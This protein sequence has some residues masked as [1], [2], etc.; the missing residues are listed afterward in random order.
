MI[1]SGWLARLATYGGLAMLR[2]PQ[3]RHARL[4]LFAALL[5]T[6]ALACPAAPAVGASTFALDRGDDPDPPAQACTTTANDCSLRGALLAANA[7]PG[8][9]T[10]SL[11]AG[12]YTLSIKGTDNAAHTGDLD[13][14]ESVAIVG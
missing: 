11:T 7:N 13:I 9:D 2:T 8:A 6:F 4:T 5:A 1:S 3:Q 14:T 12:T 10:I